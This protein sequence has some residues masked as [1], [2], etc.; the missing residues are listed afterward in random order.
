MSNESQ[1]QQ[2]LEADLNALKQFTHDPQAQKQAV[3]SAKQIKDAMKKRWFT[4]AEM[5]KKFNVSYNDCTIKLEMLKVFRLCVSKK[6]VYGT[7]EY[8]IVFDTKAE[9]QL[10]IQEIDSLEARLSILKDKLELLDK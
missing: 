5:G 1:Q 2:I 4:V 3:A 6:G 10:I 9:R 7:I 8:Q